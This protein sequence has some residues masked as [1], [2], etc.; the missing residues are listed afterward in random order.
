[1]Y[2]WPS[3]FVCTASIESS[4]RQSKILPPPN[5]RKF[6]KA[7]FGFSVT[8]TIYIIFEFYL[9]CIAATAK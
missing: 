6:Q 7:K 5:S 4:N 2:S 9:H 3:S 8:T 1:M